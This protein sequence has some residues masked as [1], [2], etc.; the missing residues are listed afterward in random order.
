MPAD[1]SGAAPGE[2]AMAEAP[3]EVR[4]PSPAWEPCP[5]GAVAGL[6]ARLRARRRRLFLGSA[7]ATLAAAAAAGGAWFA[8]QMTRERVYD[9]GGITCPEVVRLGPDYAEGKLP[10]ETAGRIRAHVARCP[11]CGPYYR[12]HGWPT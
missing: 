9:Y 6:A 11:N 12:E 2:R 8:W 7:A 10:A 1:P 3:N 4:T 5:P